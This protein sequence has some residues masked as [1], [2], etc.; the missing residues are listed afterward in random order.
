MDITPQHPAGPASLNNLK[1]QKVPGYMFKA[2]I[3]ACPLMPAQA[4]HAVFAEH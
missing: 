3:S 1:A 2:Q 4:F